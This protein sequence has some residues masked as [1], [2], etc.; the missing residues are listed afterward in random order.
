MAQHSSHLQSGP[1]SWP[2]HWRLLGSLRHHNFSALL[3]QVHLYTN[4]IVHK[5]PVIV[6]CQLSTSYWM[7]RKYFF[8]IVIMF[9]FPL[10]QKISADPQ[11]KTSIEPMSYISSLGCQCLL[12]WF[13]G[14]TLSFWIASSVRNTYSDNRGREIGTSACLEDLLE[15]SKHP[16]AFAPESPPLLDVHLHRTPSVLFPKN[17][18][19]ATQHISSIVQSWLQYYLS[20]VAWIYVAAHKLLGLKR[21]MKAFIEKNVPNKHPRSGSLASSTSARCPLFTQRSSAPD[22]SKSWAE[23][24]VTSPCEHVLPARPSEY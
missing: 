4:V 17:T 13:R 14:K 12:R 9:Y 1:K 7:L 6:P 16:E 3:S 23:I 15:P 19:L 21:S 24:A 22:A 5:W 18:R 20:H 10:F 2:P 11:S 8:S